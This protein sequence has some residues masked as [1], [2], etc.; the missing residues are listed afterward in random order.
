MDTGGPVSIATSEAA[1]YC[2]LRA[3]HLTAGCFAPSA[4]VRA[5]LH[6]L[7]VR[8][9]LTALSTPCAGFG[10]DRARA[11]VHLRSAKHKVGAG[12]AHLGTVQQ[13][14]DVTRFRVL[15]SLLETVRHRRQTDR[16]TIQTLLDALLHTTLGHGTPQFLHRVW[17]LATRDTVS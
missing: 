15:A 17:Q 10:A 4:S 12:D 7:V 16:M 2:V 3:C 6:H 5:L 1:R 11:H 14:P 9:L 13:L 8:H